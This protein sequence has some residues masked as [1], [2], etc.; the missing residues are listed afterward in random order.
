VVRDRYPFVAG[1]A[2]D[3]P[4]A[5]FGRLFGYGGVFDSFFKSELEEL[6]D[7]SHSPWT[8]RADASG[9]S[10]GPSLAILRQFE[11]AQRIREMFFRPGGQEAEVRFR[12]TPTDLDAA[13][14]RFV[15]EIDGQSFENRHGPERSWQA[16][17]PG[18][19]PGPAAVTFEVRAGARPN[20]EF[21][22]A[23]AW[24]RLIDVARAERETEVRHVLTFAKDG[25]EAR[26]R[27]DAASIRNPFG[28]D[29]LQQFRCDA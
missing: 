26:V 10:V 18:Q 27:I 7:T 20:T 23:W 11:A 8:W 2:V 28:K 15:L 9:A 22:G 16:T 29:D 6:V 13:A 12:V 4:L 21:Q 5:D 1:S 14:T 25:H 24:F 19:S 17:W 3:V